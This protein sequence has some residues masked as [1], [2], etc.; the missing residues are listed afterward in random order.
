MAQPQRPADVHQDELCPPNKRYALMDANKKVDLENPLCPNES[1]ILANI[2]QNHP[3]KFSIVA[4]SSVPWIYLGQFWHTLQ[5]DRSKYNLKFMLDRKEL[6]MTLDDFKTI[7]HLPQAT[8]NIHNRF[9]PALKFSEMVPFYVNNLGF[10]LES[11]STSNFKTT[12]LLQPWQ[13]LCKM[14]LRCLTTCV[15]GYDQPSLQIMQMLYYFVNNIH[16]D[17][18]ELLWEGF[19]YSLTNPT[20]MIP[21]PRFIKLI[22]SHYMTTF[23]GISRRACDRYHNLVDDVMIKSIFNS[24][25]SKGVVGMKIPD[26]MINEDMKLTENY[27]LY[28]EV[29]GVNVPTTQ[30]QLIESTQGTHRTTS[31]PRTP[32]PVVAEGESS[33]PRSH[34]EGEARENVEKVKEHLMAEE[35][36]KLVNETENVEENVEAD[37]STLR[38][39][40]NPNDPGARLEPISDKESLEVEITVVVQPVN[41]LTVTDPQPSSST[42]SSSSPK[43]KLSTTN[44]LLSLFK[45]KPGRFKRYK[46]FFQELQG[47]YGYLFEHLSARFMPRR[48][49][50]MIA[51]RLQEMMLDS[52][53]KLVDDRIKGILKTQVPLHVAQGLILERE[54]SQAEVAK[55]IDDA[56][57]Q[58][59]ENLRTTISSQVNDAIANHIPSQTVVRPRDQEDPHDDAHPEGENSAKRQKTSKHGTFVSGESSYAQDYESEPGLSTSGNQDQ[60]DDFDFWTDSYATDD[61]ELSTDKV[62]QE[63]VEELSQTVDE[64]KLHK[65][66][67]DMLRQ[68]FSPH[69]QRPT[70]VIQSC[71]RDPNALALSLVNQDLLY[72]KKGSS[73]PEKIVMSLYKFLAVIF[74]D[75]DIEERTSRWVK[76]YVKKFNPDTQYNVEHL[77]NPHAKIFYIKKQK[78]PDKPKEVVYSN[79]RIVQ[80]IKTYWELGHEHKFVTEIVANERNWGGEYS[81]YREIILPEPQNKND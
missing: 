13:T 30:S 42:P 11:R 75:D 56:I 31:A 26:W 21:Y 49:F 74:L 17:Y 29:F 43:S 67:N 57:Q 77:K 23:P 3:L 7:F 28:V 37:S 70:P 20:T 9:V 15:T 65:V 54:K 35:I 12:G 34:E 48:N 14:F 10:T 6:T 44:R 50:N 52:L 69:P 60:L 38:N 19:H 40:D 63:L 36:E 4:S 41:E 61:D 73:R 55:M 79:S 76:K 45:S 51:Q 80:I 27:R 81:V 59:R 2:L 1:R 71:Q 53:P 64:V 33:A 46:S 72:L 8:D 39:D 66:V 32:N 16:V 62:S 25:K 5:E 18:A 78:E 68:R 47:R 58:E 22:V 24:G